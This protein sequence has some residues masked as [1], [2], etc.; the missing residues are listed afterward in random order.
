M[1]MQVA[2][3][4]RVAAADGRSAGRRVGCVLDRLK[5]LVELINFFHCVLSNA[6]PCLKRGDDR[7]VNCPVHCTN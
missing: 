2:C 5:I 6:S 1:S 7:S 4:V 3:S